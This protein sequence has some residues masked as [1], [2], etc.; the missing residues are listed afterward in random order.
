MFGIDKK[1]ENENPYMPYVQAKYEWNERYGSLIRDKKIWQATSILSV[2]AN[3]ICIISL[4][5]I[6]FKPKFV[7]YVVKVTSQGQPIQIDRV[8]ANTKIDSAIIIYQLSQFIT[9]IRTITTDGKLKKIMMERVRVYCSQNAFNTI[10]DYWIKT[11]PDVTAQIMSISVQIDSVL[12]LA[13]SDSWQINWTEVATKN[14]QQVGSVKWTAILNI[15]K[16]KINSELD[17]IRNPTGLLIK[18]ISWSQVY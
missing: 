8:D 5:N 3:I 7:P 14:G 4:V 9:D 2:L 1:S 15:G 18:S 13:D 6:A 10:Q 17:Y 12:P 16:N 11:P